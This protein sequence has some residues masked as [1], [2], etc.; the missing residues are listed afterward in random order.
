MKN[1]VVILIVFMLH[2][3]SAVPIQNHLRG[4]CKKLIKKQYLWEGRGAVYSGPFFIADR[5]KP[6]VGRMQKVVS[7]LRAGQRVEIVEVLKDANGSWGQ[8]LRIQV[9]I[10]DGEF[11]GVVADIP[12]SAPGHPKEKWT[13]NFTLD[14]N[15][16]EFNEEI[17]V[18]CD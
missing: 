14:P 11:S 10:L 3:C 18:P 4:E 12:V 16:L 2:G 1:V 9:R 15:A 7:E 6:Q 8:Y 5:K 17:V 13:K